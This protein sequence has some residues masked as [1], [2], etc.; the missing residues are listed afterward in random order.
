[1]P[2]VAHEYAHIHVGY[3]GHHL[4]FRTTLA[5]LCLGL[6]LEPPPSEVNSDQLQSWPPYPSR[7][8]PLDFW[9]DVSGVF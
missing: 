2:V 4:A 6:G 8:N 1:L 3:P 7:T 5:H 9:L